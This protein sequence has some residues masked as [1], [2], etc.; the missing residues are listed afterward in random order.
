M[1][2]G[3]LT[4]GGDCP[5]LNPAIRGFVMKA[6]DYGF[7]VYGIREG[8]KGLVNDLVDKEPLTIADV[9]E[10]IDKGGTVLR[11]SRTNPYKDPAQLQA[12]KTTI[13]KHGFEAIV[14]LGG[15]D[16][17]GVASKL[18]KEGINTV[19][20]PKTMDNDLSETDYTFGFDSAVQV[21]VEALDRLRDTARSHSRVIVLEV[22]GR[23]AGWVALY[24]GVAGGADYI[25][26]PEVPLNVEELCTQVQRAYAR[27]GYALVVASEGVE[28]PEEEHKE[29]KVD[30][31]GHV[32]LGERNVGEWVA[33]EIEKR[34]GLET[35]S[36]VTGHIQRGGAPSAFDRVL[37]SRLGVR[38]AQCVYERDFGKMVALH[39]NDIV[40]APLEAAVG[41]LRTVPKALY[42]SLVP[43]F[44][45]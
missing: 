33:K 42:D 9:E 39:G 24:T 12:V 45:K 20:V 34:T 29:T 10:L 2:V 13:Q 28:L 18:Y 37:A 17:L 25:L 26:L 23:H 30:A 43:L 38:A 3:I 4:G 22:M 15:E 1:K 40:V 19:G 16:T 7:A 5:G 14:A 27:K 32:V 35:R 36:A 8:W 44:N 21:N 41:T 31:F 11:S 6:L